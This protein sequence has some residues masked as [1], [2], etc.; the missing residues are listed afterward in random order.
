MTITAAPQRQIPTSVPQL[1]WTTRRHRRPVRIAL[2]RPAVPRPGSAS[3]R[4]TPPM[5]CSCRPCCRSRPA[6]VPR[7]AVTARS[8]RITARPS[9]RR[10]W[11]LERWSARPRRPRTRAPR[12]SAWARPGAAQGQ[13]PGAAWRHDRRGQGAGHGNLRHAGMLKAGPGREAQGCRAST[14]TT[15]TSTPR[16]SSTARSSARTAS[17]TASTPWIRCARPASRSAA[18]AS[19]AWARRAARAPACWRNWPTWRRRP[20]RC[21]STTWCRC[22]ARRWKTRRRS[23]PSSSCAPSPWRASSCRLQHGAPVGRAARR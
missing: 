9:A 19:S 21:R 10:C 1:R 6:A 8:R 18:A 12:A 22:P 14:T 17:R 23:T 7:T 20:N 4:I 3:R 2:Q 13:G 5:P 15:T 16:R 11:M